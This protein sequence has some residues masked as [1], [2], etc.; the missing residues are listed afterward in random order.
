MT[1][2]EEETLLKVMSTLLLFNS[3]KV[4][5]LEATNYYTHQVKDP[6][7]SLLEETYQE[8]LWSVEQAGK[9]DHD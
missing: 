1:G 3:R 5:E 8:Y 9:K 7:K 6:L 4:R 2:G